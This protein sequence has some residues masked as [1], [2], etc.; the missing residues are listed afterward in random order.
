MGPLGCLA[1]FQCLIETIVNSI[2]NVIVFI[3]DLLVHSA[4]HEEHLTT[5]NQVLNRLV[6]HHIKINLKKCVFGSMKVLYL[7]FCLTEEGIKPGTDK[8][9]TVKNAALPSSVH[10]G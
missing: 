4:T 8:L 1:S 7:G 9:K 10:K 5:L 3:N 2:S 6:Q